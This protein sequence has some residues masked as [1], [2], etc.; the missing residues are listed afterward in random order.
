METLWK[1]TYEG[2]HTGIFSNFEPR[3]SNHR[4]A[5]K[6]PL[7]NYVPSCIAYL[8]SSISSEQAILWYYFLLTL[9]RWYFFPKIVIRYRGEK[10][11]A[12][13]S[14]SLPTRLSTRYR[15]RRYRRKEGFRVD[16][17]FFVA[18]RMSRI[19]GLVVRISG[20]AVR[21]NPFGYPCGSRVGTMARRSSGLCPR[22]LS[23]LVDHDIGYTDG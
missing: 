4:A 21:T 5:I 6:F 23:P 12:N 7:L 22:L 10:L 14:A 19:V 16:R 9:E 2:I 15:L 1:I 8:E 13:F 17:T 3:F 18:V 20:T 11:R